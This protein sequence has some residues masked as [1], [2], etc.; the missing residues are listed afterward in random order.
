MVRQPYINLESLKLTLISNST[1]SSPDPLLT[2]D[3]VYYLIKALVYAD[4]SFS[5]EIE[6]VLV[7][8]G[9]I[10]IPELIKN[11]G[12]DSLNVRSIAAMALIRLG[13]IAEEPLL[14]AYSK[15]RRKSSTCWVFDFIFQELGLEPLEQADQD[16]I[17]IVT[18][19]KAS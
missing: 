18:L 15:Q 1:K 10:A 6:N 3:G 4:A 17:S 11:L 2:K 19:E 13:K 5:T 7:K 12:S 8:A 9:S 16:L 14:K